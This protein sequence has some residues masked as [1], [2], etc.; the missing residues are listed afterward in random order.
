MP[1]S[2]YYAK[3]PRPQHRDYLR[4]YLEARDV[5]ETVEELDDFRL[6][7]RRRGMSGVRVYLTNSYEIGVADVEEIL[8]EA[9]ETTCI[10]STMDYNHYSSEAKALA[11]ERGVGLFKAVEFLGAVYFDGEAFLG[12]LSPAQR[13]A[14]RGRSSS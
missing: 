7:V 8:A 12:Y 3:R 5:V 14:L 2:G 13:E 6:V 11:T 4:R 9:P 10:V 1:E